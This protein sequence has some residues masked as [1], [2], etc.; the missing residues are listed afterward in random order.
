ML[1]ASVSQWLNQG[2]CSSLFRITG[3]GCFKSLKLQNNT[4]SRVKITFWTYDNDLIQLNKCI[5]FISLY[6]I[7]SLK[8]LLKF[9]FHFSFIFSLKLFFKKIK[10]LQKLFSCAVNRI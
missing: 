7:I 3:Y 1:Y 4:K 2:T 10:F 6:F 8:Y 9:I 5:Q